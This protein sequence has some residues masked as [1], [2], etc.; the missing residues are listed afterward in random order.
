[1][2][3]VRGDGLTSIAT[4]KPGISAVVAHATS[5][6]YSGTVALI[7]STRRGA[8]GFYLLKVRYARLRC[9]ILNTEFLLLT[10][11]AIVFL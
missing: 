10:L 5:S 9:F 1:M 3:S 4:G 8:T 2:F 11:L 6:V 7:K